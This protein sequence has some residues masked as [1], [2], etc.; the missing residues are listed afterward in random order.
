[1]V[2]VLVMLG[3]SSYSSDVIEHK[4]AFGEPRYLVPL[5]PLLGAVIALAVRGAGRRLAPVAGAAMVVLFLG[6]DIFSQLQV[7]ARYYG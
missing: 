7:I 2:G 6:H 1:T 4:Y 5:I 3:V